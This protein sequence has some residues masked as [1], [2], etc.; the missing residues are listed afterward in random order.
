ML[1][2]KTIKKGNNGQYTGFINKYSVVIV[3]YL[4]VM[5][6]LYKK[7]NELNMKKS[8]VL[9]LAV[10]L[11]VGCKDAKQDKAVVRN[12]KVDTVTVYGEVS[13]STFPGKVIASS[14]INLAFRVGG[15]I[16][17]VYVGVGSYV[18][19]GQVLAEIDSRD[20]EVQLAATEAEYNRI[21]NE[22]ERIAKL[23]EKGT[24]TPNDYDKARFGYKQI[25][26]KLNAHRNALKDT[27]LIAPSDGY[28]QKRLFE[29]GETVGAGMPVISM[30][31]TG[32]G[33][34]EINIPSS[35]YIRRESFDSYYCTVDIY[36]GKTF[37]LE[38]IG[39]TRKANANQLYTMRFRLKDENKEM[40][41]PGM[42]VM[43]TI[44]YKPEDSNM[45]VVPNVA[46]FNADNINK[47]WVY[48]KENE[49]VS[50]KSVEL[51]NI[52]SN[53]MAVIS[54]GL[55]VGDVVVSA[56]VHSLKEGEKVKLLPNT[57]ST[58]IGGM[59]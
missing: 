28:V 41:G 36:S 8:L 18:R 1:Y 6:M 15:P 37:N 16:S 17:K 13:S 14:D 12:V 24:V 22:A 34:V 26:S 48:N 31:N 21:K 3:A 27:K 4:C 50:A 49:T 57:S 5:K 53:G 47:V 43:V 23:Y 9:M 39:I 35:D 19:K 56:G 11:L 25:E 52:L 51:V 30:I 59:L 46:V 58:N 45:V 33:E 7:I 29:P 2:N 32:L 10:F 55:T 40:P 38:P 44:N 54:S 20:Y 42:S